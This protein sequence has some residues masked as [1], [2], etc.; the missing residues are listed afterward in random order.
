M[1]LPIIDI[2][3]LPSFDELRQIATRRLEFYTSVRDQAQEQVD[4]A[5]RVIDMLNGTP[6]PE[7]RPE[8]SRVSDRAY[9][10]VLK[11][12][13]KHEYAAVVTLKGEAGLS[14]S[15]T[16]RALRLGE[17][18]KHVSVQ[19]RAAGKHRYALTDRGKA[20]VEEM[21]TRGDE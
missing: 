14:P 5:Q 15:Q 18:N 1:T 12:L 3:D 8:V 16:N 20:Y 4:T 13:S 11:A 2:P 19:R 6:A 21:G 17:Q 7:N 10:Q 9:V